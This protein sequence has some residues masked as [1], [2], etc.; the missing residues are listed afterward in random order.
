MSPEIKLDIRHKRKNEIYV[1]IYVYMY[2]CIYVYMCQFG[3]EGN[4]TSCGNE[5]KLQPCK[6]KDYKGTCFYDG[7]VCCHDQA[8]VKPYAR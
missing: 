2:T 3:D 6:L 7:R 8:V 5:F 1:C 4:G